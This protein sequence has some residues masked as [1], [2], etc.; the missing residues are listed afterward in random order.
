MPKPDL[1]MFC[2]CSPCECNAKKKSTPRPRM[3]KKEPSA[4]TPEA[5]RQARPS[6]L[7]SMRTASRRLPPKAP[8]VAHPT[9]HQQSDDDAELVKAIQVVT[10]I[11]GG[12]L[13]EEADITRLGAALRETPDA[14]LRAHIWRTRKEARDDPTRG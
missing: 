7:E 14:K 2:N 11:L 4:E 3:V 12:Q 5:P 9:Y 13:V 8:I 10:T 1:C 6:A